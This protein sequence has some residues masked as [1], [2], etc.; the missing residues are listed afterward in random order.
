MKAKYGI[1]DKDT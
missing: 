1:A